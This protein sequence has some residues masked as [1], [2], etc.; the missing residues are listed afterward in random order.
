MT[1]KGNVKGTKK[2]K[3][4]NRPHPHQKVEYRSKD[5]N[6]KKGIKPGRLMKMYGAVTG[7]HDGMMIFDQIQLKTLVVNFH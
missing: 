2:P 5:S 6:R 7:Q 3:V 4:Q 1:L